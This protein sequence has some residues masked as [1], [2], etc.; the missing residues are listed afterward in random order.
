GDPDMAA[1]ELVSVIE[2]AERKRA[3]LLAVRPQHE[4]KVLRALPIDAKRYRDQIRKG[5]LSSNPAECARA[6]VAIRHLL[7]DR[8]VL[9]PS[10]DGT[11][12]VAHLAFQRAAL[13]LTGTVGRGDR[14]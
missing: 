9:K 6:R 1:D 13:L 3:A 11:H 8:I 5:W 2:S 4:E 12:L 14:I 10:K 7:G